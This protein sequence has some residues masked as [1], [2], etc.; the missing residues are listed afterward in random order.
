MQSSHDQRL[1]PTVADSR[2]KRYVMERSWSGNSSRQLCW[3]AILAL[4]V[5]VPVLAAQAQIKP[6]PIPLKVDLSRKIELS[7]RQS[8]LS[9]Y[10]AKA[11]CLLSLKTYGKTNTSEVKFVHHLFDE[12]L[13]DLRTGSLVHNTL[14]E[15]DSEILSALDAVDVLWETF[16][17]A[18]LEQ[19]LAVIAAQSPVIGQKLDT[20]VSLYLKKY[21][22]TGAVTQPMAT[23]LDISGRQSML[24]QKASEE[25][26]FI[27]AR[28]DE[29]AHRKSL[30]TTIDIIQKSMHSLA[31]GDAA[32]GLDPPSAGEIIDQI[33]RA[34]EEWSH[35][36]TILSRIAEGATPTTDDIAAVSSENVTVMQ[37]MNVI[38]KLY[39]TISE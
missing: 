19:D 35:M 25:F 8:M 30:K 17:P 27:A 21:E 24:T 13:L 38:V 37:A 11:A 28:R 15:S 23:A 26:C 6:T 22:S 2:A 16:G 36:N 4:F 3:L 29:A 31:T 10:M 9:Q 5:A 32:L 20:V 18:V 39:E 1:A 34:D 7:R 14:P 12:T 33:A